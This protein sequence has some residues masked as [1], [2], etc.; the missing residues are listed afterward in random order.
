MRNPGKWVAAA[1]FVKRGSRQLTFRNEICFVV[2]ELA[3]PEL[4]GLTDCRQARRGPLP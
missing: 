2:G 1:R 4:L 3:T